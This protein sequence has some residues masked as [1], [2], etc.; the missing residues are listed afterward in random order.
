MANVIAGCESDTVRSNKR[1]EESEDIHTAVNEKSIKGTNNVFQERF[2]ITKSEASSLKVY[3]TSRLEPPRGEEA[4]ARQRGEREGSQ[5]A[6]AGHHQDL[7]LRF[8]HGR[9][10]TVRSL[11]CDECWMRSR[12]WLAPSD[13]WLA[14]RSEVLMTLR[15]R[16]K[17]AL[18]W[19]PL[20]AQRGSLRP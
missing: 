14:P 2:G 9:D 11:S 19:P 1:V 16:S 10:L 8:T 18:P 12:C 13:H 4:P 7:L 20:L 15:Q 17:G 6:S 5:M 3:T